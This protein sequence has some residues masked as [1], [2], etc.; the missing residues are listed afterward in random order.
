MSSQSFHPPLNFG[1]NPYMCVADTL[2]I[3]E[4]LSH[5]IRAFAMSARSEDDYAKLI[6]WEVENFNAAYHRTFG[7]YPTEGMLEKLLPSSHP[8]DEA[9]NTIPTLITN[10]I[11]V[12]VVSSGLTYLVY[13]AAAQL[14]IKP[15]N[16]FANS[17]VYDDSTGF[18][19]DIN[20]VVSG[21]KSNALTKAMTTLHSLGVTQE[22]IAYVGDNNWDVDAMNHMLE[23]GGLVFYLQPEHNE[24]LKMYPLSDRSLLDHPRLTI[25]EDLNQLALPELSSTMRALICDADG[26]IIR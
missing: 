3:A 18:L 13:P 11:E 9:L 10:G 22:E 24:D 8:T 12:C 2:G 21:N 14:G 19:T 25:I 16:I 26:T 6:E 5:R 15:T 4:E 23:H 17:F 1:E 7:E 20:V